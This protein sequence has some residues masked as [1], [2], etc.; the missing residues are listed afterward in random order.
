ML[1]NT[2]GPAM[3]SDYF[4]A[5]MK[6]AQYEIIEDGTYWGKIPGFQGVWANEPTL[7][8][9]RD[10][11]QSVLEDWVLVKLWDNDDDLPVLGKLSLN[12]SR[13]WTRARGPSNKTRARKA[14]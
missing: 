8:A 10:E 2:E 7:E 5:A 1:G 11:L 3:F 6:L 4:K 14:S 9:C 12:P 13:K